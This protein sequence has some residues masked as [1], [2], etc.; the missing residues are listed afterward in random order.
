MT[1]QHSLLAIAGAS[2]LSALAMFYW[3]EFGKGGNRELRAALQKASSFNLSFMP[4]KLSDGFKIEFNGIDL[5]QF[6]T[7][8]GAG[9]GERTSVE[10]SSA[11][12]SPRVSK[13][14]LPLDG[15]D[16]GASAESGPDGARITLPDDWQSKTCDEIGHRFAVFGDG[17][18]L[19]CTAKQATPSDIEQ[20][21]STDKAAS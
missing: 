1:P 5:S 15:G 2:F 16:K 8:D 4:I 12:P 18:C 11:R 10:Q 7:A 3:C 19:R 6:F 17:H 13:R 9:K 14:T 21:R 20:I